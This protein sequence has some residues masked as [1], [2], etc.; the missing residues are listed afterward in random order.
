MFIF[1]ATMQKQDPTANKSWYEKAAEF[2]PIAGTIIAGKDAYQY[3]KNGDYA[4]GSMMTTAA[5]V[6]AGCDVLMFTGV[7]TAAGAAGKITVGN[8]MRE[9]VGVGAKTGN[10]ILTKNVSRRDLGKAAKQ[11]VGEARAGASAAEELTHMPRLGTTKYAFNQA[12]TLAAGAKAAATRAAGIKVGASVP[13][14]RK[15]VGALIRQNA[16]VQ[17]SLNQSVGY[18]LRGSVWANTVGGYGLELGVRKGMPSGYDY[19]EKQQ[20][21]PT[22]PESP[23]RMRNVI[24]Q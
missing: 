16:T 21:Q 7:F 5:L 15:S 1:Q 2:V 18:I 23:S 11:L 19:F 24:Q 20:C 9:L 3:F 22:T 13:A 8:A 17:N 12:A 14:M 4:K 10:Y 6:S